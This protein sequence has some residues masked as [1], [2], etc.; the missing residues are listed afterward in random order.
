MDDRKALIEALVWLESE[1]YGVAERFI[2][3][4]SLDP[5]LIDEVYTRLKECESEWL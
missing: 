5:S 1:D 4:N 3:E 2:K